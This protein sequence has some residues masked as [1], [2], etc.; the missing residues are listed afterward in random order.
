MKLSTLGNWVKRVHGSRPKIN[1]TNY[2][3]L[4]E[5][6]VHP[7]IRFQVRFRSFHRRGNNQIYI[8]NQSYLIKGLVTYPIKGLVTYPIKGFAAY[9]IKV[10][11]TYSIEELV[12]YPIEELVK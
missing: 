9:P 8:P 4:T 1:C 2:R 7:L 3:T 10:L 12:T 11:I 6:V 5:T